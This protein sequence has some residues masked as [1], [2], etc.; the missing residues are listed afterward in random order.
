MRSE[1]PRLIKNQWWQ[2]FFDVEKA[3]NMLW[4]EGLLIK[5]YQMGIEGNMFNWIMGFLDGRTIQVKIGMWS[6]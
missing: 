3:Y 5:L 1:E 4:R 2:S 6:T